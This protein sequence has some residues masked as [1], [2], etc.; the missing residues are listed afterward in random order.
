MRPLT[1]LSITFSSF[2]TVLFLFASQT[3]KPESK[4][5][6]P[7][8]PGRNPPSPLLP[9]HPGQGFSGFS[10]PPWE[11]AP[12]T[13]GS[14]SGG[15]QPRVTEVGK[16]SYSCTMYTGTQ[17]GTGA[18]AEFRASELCPSTLTS[19]PLGSRT[20]PCS[21]GDFHRSLSKEG[22]ACHLCA[23]FYITNSFESRFTA[24]TV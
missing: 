12:N 17:R 15:K 22:P 4:Q 20:P 13:Q 11:W 3:H 16:R 9:P 21:D 8:S 24:K 2:F 19:S 23:A 6:P 14:L 18:D 7:V 5:I 10:P 1:I